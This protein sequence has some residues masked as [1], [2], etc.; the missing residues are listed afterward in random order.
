[1]QQAQ[2]ANYCLDVSG[3]LACFTRPE[4]KV[5]RVSYDI[6][7]PSAVR[8]IFES[9]LWKPAIRWVPTA[10]EVLPH[11]GYDHSDSGYVEWPRW[12]TVRRNEVG[13]VANSRDPR[14]IYIEE[15]RQQ[16]A[17][18]LLRD[19]HYRLHARMEFIPVGQRTGEAARSAHSDETP[20]KYRAMFERRAG[21]GQ[22]FNQPYLGCREFACERVRLVSATDSNPRPLAIDRDLG[23]MLYDLDFAAA[24]P[25]QPVRPMF[26]HASVVSGVMN[27]PAPDSAEVLR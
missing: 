10:V 24:A 21:K 25:G 18:L 5:E 4:F 3:P 19:V 22:V 23:L 13:K 9:I 11:S 14:P 2:D 1:M 6:I 17:A 16:K 12:S 20:E 15:H 8:A 7:T 26:Y 27:I